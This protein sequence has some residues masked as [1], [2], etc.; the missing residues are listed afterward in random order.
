MA[1]SWLLAPKQNFRRSQTL[2]VMSTDGQLPEIDVPQPEEGPNPQEVL[3]S[4]ATCQ[5][6]I[7]E[8]LKFR[9][10]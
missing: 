2:T 3:D 5:G 6:K 1:K 4:I 8:S 7:P 9:K 10:P